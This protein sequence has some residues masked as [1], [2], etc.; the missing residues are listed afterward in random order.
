[1]RHNRFNYRGT[2]KC[3]LCERNTRDTGQGVDHLC[4]MCFEICGMDNGINDSG[5]DEHGYRDECNRLLK[6]I[7]KKGGNVERVKM[8]NRFVWEKAP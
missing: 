5:S 1:M 6:I 7:E 3:Q 2:F 8:H 4:A